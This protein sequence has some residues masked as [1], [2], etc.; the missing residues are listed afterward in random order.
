MKKFIWHPH[1][2]VS[3]VVNICGLKSICWLG[4]KANRIKD[5]YAFDILINLTSDSMY[6]DRGIDDEEKNKRRD[7]HINENNKQSGRLKLECSHFPTSKTQS[8]CPLYPQKIRS[9]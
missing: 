4:T 5:N 2:G 7:V 3:N 8:K 6:H 9:G 1:Q